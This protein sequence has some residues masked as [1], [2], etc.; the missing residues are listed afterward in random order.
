MRI[1]IDSLSFLL[2]FVIASLSWFLYDRVRT[3]WPK[4]KTLA[5]RWITEQRE[6]NLSGLENYLR[7]EAVERAQRQHLA[8]RMFALE[9]ILVE[10]QLLAA[11]ALI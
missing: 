6:R 8:A 7:Q 3:A 11:P 10:P 1:H 4:W 5:E 9:D 2:G